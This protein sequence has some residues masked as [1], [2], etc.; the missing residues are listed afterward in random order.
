MKL[1]KH[2]SLEEF[3]HSQTAERAGIENKPDADQTRRMI[4]LCNNVLEP[5][6]VHF[7][8]PL[9]IDS[10]FRCKALN[11]LVPNS[12]NTSQHCK[13]EAA[14]IIIPGVSLLEVFEYIKENLEFDQCIYEI[15]WVHVS[16]K[17]IGNRR[18][19]LGARSENHKVIYEAWGDYMKGPE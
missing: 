4:L 3:T 13:G 1:S 15:K 17:A 6:R 19:V 16:F 9:R 5:T 10:G 7:D 2:F 14:D 8:K 12:S 18:Q 11:D